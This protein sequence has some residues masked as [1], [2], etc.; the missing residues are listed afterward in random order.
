DPSKTTIFYKRP[1]LEAYKYLHDIKNLQGVY[2]LSQKWFRSGAFYYLHRNVPIYFFDRP[3]G[4]MAYISHIITDF[5]IANAPEFQLEKSI[6]EVNI[7][8]RK[9]KNFAYQKD[10][11]YNYNF[12]QPGVDISLH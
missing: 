2:D 9:N 12:L 1:Q 6:G 4:N 11:N 7:Y 8:G 5:P 3:P 10:P